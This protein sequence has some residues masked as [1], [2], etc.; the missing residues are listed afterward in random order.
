MIVGGWVAVRPEA[1]ADPTPWLIGV[2]I[3]L[4]VVGA[5]STKDFGDVKG[6]REGGAFT[7]VVIYGFKKAA[8]IIAPLCLSSFSARCQAA[9]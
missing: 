3:F 1:W 4:F 6:D 2:I 9:L 7:V 8:W 5:A